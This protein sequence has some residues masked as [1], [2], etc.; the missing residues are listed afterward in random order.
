MRVT[1]SASPEASRPVTTTCAY[2]NGPARRIDGGWTSRA[3]KLAPGGGRLGLGRARG[4]RAGD[5]RGRGRDARRLAPQGRGGELLED[6]PALRVDQA[7][8][9]VAAGGGELPVGPEGDGVD[10]G[11]RHLDLGDQ[12]QALGLVLVQGDLLLGRPRGDH[13]LHDRLDVVGQA[14]V[15]LVRVD[16]DLAGAVEAAGRG[17]PLAVAADGD[18]EDAPGHRRQARIRLASS[19]M[20]RFVRRKMR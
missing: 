17:D 16:V 13:L 3:A 6:R 8:R 2:A 14:G 20:T 1:S 10:A 15:E 7:H 11:L 12:L 18:A 9:A 5:R 4:R 19:P